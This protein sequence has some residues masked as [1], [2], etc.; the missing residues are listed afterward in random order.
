MLVNVVQELK[1]D[2]GHPVGGVIGEPFGDYTPPSWDVYF[3]RLAYDVATKSKDPSTKFGAVIVKE[4][5]PILFGFNGLPPNVK[6]HPERLTTPVKYDWIIHAEKNAIACGSKFGIATDQTA[7]YI[8]AWPCCGCAG[9]I[10]A[11]GIKKVV[12][13]KPAVEVFTRVNPKW[14][15]KI[16]QTMF[17]EAGVTVEYV[18]MFIGKPAYF[19]GRKYNL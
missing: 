7:L 8:S 12:L 19:S 10:V 13:H 1:D 17:E 4:K 16:S 2:Q 15:R 9:M 5:R 18:D 6:D 3:M 11:A 14:S